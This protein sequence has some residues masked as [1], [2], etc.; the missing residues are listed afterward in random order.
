M[1][2]WTGGGGGDGEGNWDVKVG[3]LVM[4]WRWKFFFLKCERWVGTRF[5]VQNGGVGEGF[6]FFF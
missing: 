6:F 3:G 2:G 1:G 5:L 4:M